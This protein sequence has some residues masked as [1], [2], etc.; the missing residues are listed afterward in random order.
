[1]K[2]IAHQLASHFVEVV[3]TTTADEPL[4]V[5]CGGDF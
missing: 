1:M 5:C 2:G 4:A 3:A